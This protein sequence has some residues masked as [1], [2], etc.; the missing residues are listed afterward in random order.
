MQPADMNKI[1]CFESKSSVIIVLIALSLF[2]LFL[3]EYFYPVGTDS[4]NFLYIG[5][6][7]LD[8]NIP[9]RDAWDHKGPVLYL[10]N[11]LGIAIGMGEL[12]GVLLLE[13]IIVFSAFAIGFKVIH[14]LYGFVPAAIAIFVIV[15]CFISICQCNCAEEYALIFQFMAF[16]LFYKAETASRR[17][18]F[19]LFSGMLCAGAFLLRPNL[20]GFWIALCIFWILRRCADRHLKRFCIDVIVLAS[21]FFLVCSVTAIFFYLNHA[22]D[23]ML[24]CLFWFNFSYSSRGMYDRLHA[25]RYGFTILFP[26][27]CL[28]FCAWWLVIAYIKMLPETLKSVTL[29]GMILYTIEILLSLCS[30][31]ETSK[32]QIP[33]LLP[34]AILTAFLMYLGIHMLKIINIPHI[35]IEKRA[36]LALILGVAA[37]I[38][39]LPGVQVL[40]GKYIKLLL[41]S[42]KLT[43][44][45]HISEVVNYIKYNSS[46]NDYVLIIGQNSGSVLFAA[47]RRSPTKFFYQ[48]TLNLAAPDQ[49]CRYLET[50]VK[51]ILAKTPTLI[52]VEGRNPFFEKLDLSSYQKV[53]PF[54]DVGYQV[55]VRIKPVL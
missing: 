17:L 27:S 22:L 29:F 45:K 33:W 50:F 9:Y 7:L 1:L 28:A 16:L 6:Q 31:G 49:Y 18:Q 37:V 51:D 34:I 35:K 14:K 23:D 19:N 10:F 15:Y 43:E 54:S 3:P 11:A 20:I 41:F 38:L 32:Y 42:S 36:I 4:G 46:K 55:F 2:F 52:I 30:G 40:A 26:F 5:R 47:D 53:E 12:W 25:L 39:T 21:G 8:G 13:F 48:Y 24:D 44:Q